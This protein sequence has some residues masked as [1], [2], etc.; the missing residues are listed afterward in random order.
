MTTNP[1]PPNSTYVPAK[2]ERV[3]INGRACVE[4]DGS[5]WLGLLQ[6]AAFFV[7]QGRK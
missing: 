3:R 6:T 7:N 5:K 4:M 2:P 1:P